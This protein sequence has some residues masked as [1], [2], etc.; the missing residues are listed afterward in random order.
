VIGRVEPLDD[1]IDKTPSSGFFRQSGRLGDKG[2]CRRKEWLYCLVAGVKVKMRILK[3]A[4]FA[5]GVAA[6]V[7]AWLLLLNTSYAWISSSSN[8]RVIIGAVLLLAM[9]V[10][11]FAV[12]SVVVWHI[13]N[14]V[15]YRW[16]R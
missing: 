6:L 8:L 13:A 2:L 7:I 3:I 4:V 5:L 10:L 11:T 1:V 9:A 15:K 16:R 14:G 12:G